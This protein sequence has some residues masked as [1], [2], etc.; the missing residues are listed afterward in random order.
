MT[1]TIEP[2]IAMGTWK[3]YQEDDGFVARCG[4]IRRVILGERAAAPHAV[5]DLDGR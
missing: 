4:E 3:V 5:G 1:I 2:M